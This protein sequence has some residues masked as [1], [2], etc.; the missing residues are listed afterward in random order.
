MRVRKVHKV[1]KVRKVTGVL[2]TKSIG[3]KAAVNNAPVG[4]M[5]LMDFTD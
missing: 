5:D 1:Y 3:S 2:R 4:S